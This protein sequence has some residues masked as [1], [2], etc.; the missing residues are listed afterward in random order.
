MRAITT[1]IVTSVLFAIALL[2]AV[3]TLDALV[4]VATNIAP[5]YEG[6]INNIHLA[7]VKYAVA[8]FLA[9]IVI[10][11]IFKILQTERQTVRR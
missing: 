4:P 7:V 1:L 6:T 2:V 9:T 11:A 8:V 3:P 10:Y 5:G